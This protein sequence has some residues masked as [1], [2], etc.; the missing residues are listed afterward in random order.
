MTGTTRTS[1]QFGFA[2]DGNGVTM[3]EVP[4]NRRKNAKFGIRGRLTLYRP[5]VTRSTKP[6]TNERTITRSE[7]GR[8]KVS[9]ASRIA[10]G[11]Q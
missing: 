11:V 2:E 10:S 5:T 8:P 9:A 6:S 3:R 1:A 4:A 7:L